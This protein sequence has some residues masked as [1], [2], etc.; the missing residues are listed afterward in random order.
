MRIH[1]RGR[2]AVPGMNAAGAIPV[3]A[4]LVLAPSMPNALNAEQATG[5]IRFTDVAPRSRIAYITNNNF[6][7]R[8][9]FPQ[10]MCGGIAVIDYDGDGKQD[11]FFTNGAKLPELK[12]VDASFYSCL[13]RNKGDGAFEDVTAQAGLLGEHL[14]YSY[15]VA[16]GDFDNDGDA[17]LF[18]CQT[19]PNALYRNNGDGTFADV[20][21]GS[22]LDDKQKDLLSVCAAWVDYDHD[23]LLDLIISQYTYWNPVT[24]I[25]CRYGENQEFYCHPR[26]YKSVPH[27][28]YH[29]E[30]NGRFKNVTVPSGFA[31]ASN[32]KG[33]GVG[34]AD[35][36]NDGLTDI[37]VANDTEQNF[38][39]INLGKGVF[40]EDSWPMGVAYNDEG[41]IVSGMG[42]DV[43]DFDNDGWVD[44]FYNNLQ[45][46]I[47]ALFR[48]EEGRQFRYVSPITRI[49]DLSRRF[50]GWSNG[51]IDFDNDGWKDIYSSNGDVDYV[52]NNSKQH[53]T[54]FRNMNGERFEDVS[55]S[56]GP[57]FLHLGYQR[58]SSFADLNDDGFFDLIVTS[59]NEA[60]RILLN[61]GGNGHHW[62]MVETFGRTSNREGIGARIKITTGSGRTLYNHITTTVG[63]MSSP[64]R[65]AHFGLGTE[66]TI[67][68]IEISW[69][70]GVT[71]TL[72]GVGVD[73]IIRVIEPK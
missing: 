66:E 5:A 64:D 49:A 22:G 61:S 57:D 34:I 17:D 51:F 14:D 19:G 41:T 33:M 11:I 52:G 56:L 28:L 46:Q 62:L 59:L 44:I 39:Y 73:Q 31:D 20:T 3:A 70:G 47:W 32:G 2:D 53:D 55:E 9:Y 65:R 23:G 13:L 69:P 37:F 15:G 6:T 10:P 63:F 24:D 21:K 4:L 27:D 30:G 25:R 8:K 48:N 18:L 67:K 12:R 29:N 42:T 54:I 40:R 1:K 45:G 38:L 36:N 68:S 50:S 71:Q 26:T 60:P 58:G 7:G 43:K 16:A 72:D 35:F